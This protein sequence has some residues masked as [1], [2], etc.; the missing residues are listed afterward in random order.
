M[1][2]A[3]R[4]R[5]AAT[6]TLLFVV[7]GAASGTFLGA[8]HI[9]GLASPLDRLEMLSLDWRYLLAGSRAAPRGVVIVAIDDATIKRAGSFPLPRGV[10][11][12]IVRALAAADPQVVAVDILLVDAGAPQQDAELAAALR[13]TKSVIAAGASFEAEGAPAAAPSDGPL[14]RPRR[15]LWPREEFAR[16][17]QVGITNVSTD[18]SGVPRYAPLL[19]DGGG[20]TV[21]RSFVL[22]AAAVAQ[23]T[24]PVLSKRER[25]LRL[26]GRLV[27]T[28]LGYNLPLHYYGPRGRV[29]TISAL[30][31][32]DGDL[33]AED[34]RG[35][36]VVLG[37]GAMTAGD[38]FA[39]PFDRTMPGVEVLATG[40]SNLLAGDA[41]IRDDATRRIDAAAAVLLP[42]GMVLLLAA[43]R[44]PLGAA[45]ALL[46]FALWAAAVHLAFLRGY[47]L[48]FALPAAASLPIAAAYGVAR[49][50]LE[51]RAAGRLRAEGDALRRFQP[52]GLVARLARD[53]RFLATPVA[54]QAGIVFVDL[55]A[56]TGV[57]EAL[58]PAWTQE[59][60]A[61]L[62]GRIEEAATAQQGVVVN[63]MGDGAMIVFGLPAAR[64]DDASRALRAVARLYDSLT[65]WI[66]DLP[67]VARDRLRPRIGAH[68]GP[69]VLSRLGAAD[70][71]HIT[72]TGDTVNVANRLLEVAKERHAPI[73]V[74]ENLVAAA[75]LGATD[76]GLAA[77]S[78]RATDVAIRG[79]AQTVTVRLWGRS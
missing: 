63:Y 48:S 27:D 16:S 37:F 46:L 79:R 44:I 58:G 75:A 42:I 52:P 29:Q 61:A 41:L 64:P 14:P 60:L 2:A 77:P 45:L 57:T 47:W 78:D 20:G 59:L 62:H 21:V 33:D 54:Q 76:L 43:R 25:A 8:R 28:D 73:A 1:I 70:H 71:Q 39:T 23:S 7:L 5:A 17:A 19:F 10:L 67:P 35:Q 24:E 26:G 66:A 50:S 40:I 9:A 68:F 55:S 72:A 32:L 69:V 74:S 12:R 30:W 15:I 36:V 13:S 31:A 3:G 38:S 11:A 18:R 22:A 56:F 6:L 49:L 65:H 4:F 34:V 51:Q 53:P